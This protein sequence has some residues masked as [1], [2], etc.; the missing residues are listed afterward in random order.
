VELLFKE[1]WPFVREAGMTGLALL[2]WYLERSAHQK[3]QL[4][5]EEKDKFISES[6]MG[7]VSDTTEVITDN[8]SATKKLGELVY[9]L[10][11][12]KLP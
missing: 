8:A 2:M 6:L 5:L 10:V 4:R 9:E 1:I 3:T 11:R 12:S 7:I